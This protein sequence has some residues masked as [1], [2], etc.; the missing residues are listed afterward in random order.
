MIKCIILGNKLMKESE[1]QILMGICLYI[2]Q[3]LPYLYATIVRGWRWGV[4]GVK[5]DTGQILH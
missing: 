3:S 5:G 2:F 1:R 4:V